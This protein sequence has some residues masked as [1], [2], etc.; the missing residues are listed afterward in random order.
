MF[1]WPQILAIVCFVGAAVVPAFGSPYMVTVLFFLLTSLVLAQSW[2]WVGGDMGYIN[3]AHGVH[4]GLGAYTLSILLSLGV[5]LILSFAAAALISA[6]VAALLAYPLFRMRGHYF[7]FGTLAIVPL[8]ELLA[9]NL[10]SLT[11]GADG[12]S[13]PPVNSQV[14]SYYIALSLA[15]LVVLLSIALS[16]SS[17][18]L[19][20]RCIKNDE[21]VSEAIGLR[22]FPVKVKTLAASSAFAALA[23]ATYAFQLGFID[24]PSVLGL[25]VALAPIVMALFGGSGLLWGPA[26]GVLLLGSAQQILLVQVSAYQ[27]A[28]YGCAILLIGRFMPDGV[29]RS[30]WLHRRVSWL[31]ALLQSRKPAL[32]N[33]VP[34]V[35]EH[36]PVQSH[37]IARGKVLLRCDG[38][39][40][41]FGGNTVLRN[42]NFTVRQGEILGLVG[43]NG[44]GK[45]TLFNCISGIYRPKSGQVTFDGVNVAALRR[46][47]AA[48]L[49]IA[50]TYQ[51]PRPF[52]DMTVIENIEA[53]VIFSGSDAAGTRESAL[54]IAVYV[55]LGGKLPVR[56]DTLSTQERKILEFARALACRPR[57]L[58]VDE[59]A[60]GLT[61]VEL[62][63]FIKMLRQIRDEFGITIIWIE[64]I[65]GALSQAVD[66]VI[67]LEQGALIADGSAN[68]VFSNDRVRRSYL[69][70]AIVAVGD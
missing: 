12:I 67:V 15:G 58:L 24:P 65:L 52:A 45:T 50:R 53:A 34:D 44:S 26:V 11:K 62:Q 68:D 14:T 27:V 16:R 6:G 21:E 31:H 46:D 19:A 55:G 38:V 7:A 25:S 22:T 61:P 32:A 47:E 41:A 36:P 23:G 40:M 64:H 4:F 5:P 13:L 57:L 8:A 60:S 49:G 66:R 17:F 1:K 63:R 28:L 43:P 70:S 69:P 3:L 39:T 9:F 35:T 51:I 33:P 2:N 54:R 30:D 10:R 18:G 48:R 29:L 37:K 42:V 59:V 20:L 56:A